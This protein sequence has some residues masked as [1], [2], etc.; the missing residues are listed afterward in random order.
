MNKKLA[1]F[2]LATLSIFLMFLLLTACGGS[3]PS[4]PTPEKPPV[5]APTPEPEPSEPEPSE[6]EPI[7]LPIEDS[8]LGVDLSDIVYKCP[9][10]AGK[11]DGDLFVCNNSIADNPLLVKGQFPNLTIQTNLV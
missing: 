9:A 3:E 2:T 11:Y 1:R 5:E 4:E 10:G 7:P 8:G 6:P